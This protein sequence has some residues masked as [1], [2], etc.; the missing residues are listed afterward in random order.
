MI[1]LF[2]SRY[3]M[4][5][6]IPQIVN[7]KEPTDMPE[8]VLERYNT[9]PNTITAA[10]TGPNEGLT[11][12]RRSKIHLSAN[13]ADID[14]IDTIQEQEGEMKQSVSATS[15]SKRTRNKSDQNANKPPI[16]RKPN[17]IRKTSLQ[18]PNT[19]SST[20]IEPQKSPKSQPKL[21][22]KINQ[23]GVESKSVCA[24]EE[25]VDQI[26]SVSNWNNANDDAYGISISLYEKNPITGE[27][28][29]NPIADCFGIVA[30]G[31]VTAMALADGV[32]WGE[33]A[34]TAA[35]CAIQG[36]LD[37]IDTAIFGQGQGGYA[38]TTREVFVSLLRSFWEAHGT[39]LDVGGA[40]TTLT[41]AVVL[42]LADNFKGIEKFVCL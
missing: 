14:F 24:R 21:A 1:L 9:G 36:A 27:N 25:N 8:Y 32:N 16:Y 37:Y 12:V 38:S 20:S 33:G 2:N 39:I 35:R 19:S 22:D 42:P 29:G 5:L 7:G 41:V 40:L 17:N 13:L 15:L 31:D 4:S 6:S 11:S 30:R 28:T 34:K 18:M 3:E 26:A 23:N 10:Y